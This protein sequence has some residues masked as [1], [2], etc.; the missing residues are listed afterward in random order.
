MGGVGGVLGGGVGFVECTPWRDCLMCPWRVE[1][2]V[3]DT[4][5]VEAKIDK[6]ASTSTEA[7]HKHKSIGVTSLNSGCNI[8][9]CQRVGEV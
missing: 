5:F 9:I 6:C 7:M 1:N 3:L 4:L 8:I 2:P